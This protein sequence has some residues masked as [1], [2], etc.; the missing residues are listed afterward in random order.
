MIILHTETNNLKN[1]KD[2]S[3][4]TNETVES[5][6]NINSYGNQIVVSPLLPPGDKK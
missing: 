6:K 3:D 1:N 4:I 5:A 2:L